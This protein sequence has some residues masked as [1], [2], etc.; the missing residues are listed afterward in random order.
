M[1]TN[2][3]RGASDFSLVKLAQHQTITTRRVPGCPGDHLIALPVMDFIVN[4]PVVV[5]VAVA[6]FYG[7]LNNGIQ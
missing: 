1:E 3:V 5:A 2:L 6:V 4:S 7:V